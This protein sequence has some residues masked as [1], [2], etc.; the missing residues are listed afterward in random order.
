MLLAR[1][2]D[3]MCGVATAGVFPVVK[4]STFVM[5]GANYSSVCSSHET[6]TA[7]SHAMRSA[8]INADVFVFCY[9]LV[10]FSVNMKSI[11]VTLQSFL[12]RMR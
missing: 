9:W 8:M 7:T 4:Q 12:H 10:F 2:E 11:C 6:T 5:P 1:N 3:N